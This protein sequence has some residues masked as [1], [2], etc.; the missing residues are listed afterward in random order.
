MNK[1]KIHW[2]LPFRIETLYQVKELNLASIRMR[3]GSII[4]N[5]SSS[6]FEIS[7]GENIANNIDVL[8][9][10]KLKSTSY[11]SVQFWIDKIKFAK[12][13]RTKILF[14]YTDDYLNQHNSG[15]YKPFYNFLITQADMAITSSNHLKLSLKNYFNGHIEVI[16]DPIEVLIFKPHLS[17]TQF[18]NILW[19]GHES[20]LS[21]LI[22]FINQLNELKNPT[23]IYALTS[24]RG[25]EIANQTKMTITKNL[26]SH[27]GL[28][29]IN[30]MINTAKSCDL[31]IIPSNLDDKRKNGVSSN[32]L[33]TALAL[34]LPT[35]AD[36]LDSY[37]EFENYFTDIRSEKSLELI[38]NPDKFHNQVLEAQDK[39]VP[40]FTQEAISQKWINFLKK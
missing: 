37:N 5:I 32:R 39:I 36:K 9:V 13:N 30:A 26:N 8:I 19:F 33:I 4:Q 31:C 3:L 40:Q 17:N 1:K 18:T 15:F 38:D 35:A 20:N 34:G 6:S 11:Q 29:S 23:N 10:G 12:Q 16:E 28:W 24:K 2:L 22:Q 14:D 27:F 25:I 21:Y 7:A